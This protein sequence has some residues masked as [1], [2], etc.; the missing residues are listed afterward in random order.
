M[1]GD[2]AIF[3]EAEDIE[4]HL[5]A[6]ACEII[7]AMQEDLVA[8]LEGAD[9]FHGSGHGSRGQVLDAGHKGV[10]AGAISQVVLDVVLD[11]KVVRLLS[12]AS[13]KS[14]DEIQCLLNLSCHCLVLSLD[15]VAC[16]PCGLIPLSTVGIHM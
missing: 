16:D 15:T 1:L 7:N 9:V 12:V 3:I 5:F 14:V 13:S 4:G 6:S 8:I 10:A 2:L 11:Q